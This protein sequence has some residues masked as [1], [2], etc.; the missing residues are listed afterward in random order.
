MYKFQGEEKCLLVES[1]HLVHD[2]FVRLE[3]FIQSLILAGI[4]SVFLIYMRDSFKPY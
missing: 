2:P 4:I 3:K 1:D